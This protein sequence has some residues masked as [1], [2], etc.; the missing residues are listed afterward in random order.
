VNDFGNIDFD[1]LVE[2][3]NLVTDQLLS[4]GLADKGL[5]NVAIVREGSVRHGFED[6]LFIDLSNHQFLV[7]LEISSLSSYL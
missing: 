2:R 4:I 1:E 3:L 6:T 7:H 5:E